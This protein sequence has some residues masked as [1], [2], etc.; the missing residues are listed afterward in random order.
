MEGYL[1]IILYQNWVINTLTAIMIFYIIC[2]RQPHW[3]MSF[4][5]VQN[6][7]RWPSVLR[8]LQTTAQTLH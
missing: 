4:F 3:E 7:S 6:I 5:T 2:L 8:F 1:Y